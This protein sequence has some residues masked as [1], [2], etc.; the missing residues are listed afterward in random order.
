MKFLRFGLNLFVTHGQL[1]AR[2]DKFEADTNDLLNF[3]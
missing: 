3:K 1:E 2:R